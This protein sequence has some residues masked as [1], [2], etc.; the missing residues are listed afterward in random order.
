[1]YFYTRPI[2]DGRR[3]RRA[4]TRGRRWCTW[5]VVVSDAQ[6]IPVS[7]AKSLR[8]AGDGPFKNPILK[9]VVSQKKLFC[10]GALV[11]PD[12][13]AKNYASN[14]G[15]GNDTSVCGG[16]PQFAR[17]HR[18]GINGLQT[19]QTFII[20][21]TRNRCVYFFKSVVLLLWDASWPPQHIFS[22]HRT[23]TM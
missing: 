17:P 3:R 2:P 21:P 14:R 5:I 13:L 18:Y 6:Y 12:N 8:L 11:D 7:C 9:I 4:N 10:A 23:G 22:P 15:N 20:H 16:E 1:M 19:E